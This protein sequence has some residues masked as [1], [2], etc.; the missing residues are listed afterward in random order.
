MH[1]RTAFSL[2]ELLTAL[3][4]L[5]VG[6]AAFA[7][8]A[9]AV[10]RLEN[11]ARLRRAIADVTQARLDSLAAAPCGPSRSGQ[12]QFAGIGERWTATSE[13]RRWLVSDSLAVRARPTLAR[14]YTAI[15]TC[16]R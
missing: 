4:L 11:D 6:L 8:A 10:A 14:A 13:G 12:A 5:A 9:G 15:V 2:I 7:R 1:R 16:S 3:V